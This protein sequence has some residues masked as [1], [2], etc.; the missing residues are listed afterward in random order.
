M[1]LLKLS[2]F[3]LIDS[4][5]SNKSPQIQKLSWGMCGDAIKDVP[6]LS[7]LP[8]PAVLAG[9]C[10][11]LSAPQLCASQ[12]SITPHTHGEGSQPEHWGIF[13]SPNLFTLSD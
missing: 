2:I 8:P 7:A 3:F 9:L 4:Q 13:L 12:Q 11:I 10:P 5:R 1:I 6:V